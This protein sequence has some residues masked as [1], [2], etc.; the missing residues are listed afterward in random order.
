MK[1]ILV[2]GSEGDV[3][4]VLLPQ[5]ARRF[6]AVGFDLRP[7][8]GPLKV[9]QGDLTN[10]EEVAAAMEGKEAVVHVAALLPGRPRQAP[11]DFVD[12]NV[13]APANLLQAAV[14]LGVPRFVYC[15]TVWA[16]GHGYTEPYQPID[17]EVPCAP[18]CLYGQTKWLGELM[19]E[20]YAREHGLET[21]ILRFCGFH[22]VAGYNDEGEIDWTS[23]DVPALFLRYLGAGFKLMNPVD[24]GS[25]FG[26]ALENPRAVG[27]RFIIGCSTPYTTTDA[28]GLRSMPAA[29]VD[30]Y[31][32]GASTLFAELGIRI[33]PVDYY[34]SHEKARTQLGFRSQQD[35][36]DLVRLYRE[37]QRG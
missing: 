25:A 10:Y 21:V 30:K 9:I 3:G 27:E 11:A 36:G 8:G 17:E 16:S 1:K 29:I 32:P 22:P 19:T 31:Y 2:T 15:S 6:E 18:V 26:C 34:F 13:Q 28:A 33:P 4:R 7:H 24:L 23:A 20:Y 12:G 35:L 5:L 14:E 37:W